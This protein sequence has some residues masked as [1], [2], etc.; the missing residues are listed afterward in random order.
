[1][2]LAPVASVTKQYDF[3]T[4]RSQKLNRRTVIHWHYALILQLWFE[5]S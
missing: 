2:F 4:S 1:M 5:S 3:G